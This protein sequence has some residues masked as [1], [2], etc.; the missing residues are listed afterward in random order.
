MKQTTTTEQTF[1]MINLGFDKPKHFIDGPTLLDSRF[2]YTIGELIEML[3]TKLNNPYKPPLAID[4]NNGM[5]RVYYVIP[6][7]YSW[8]WSI[9]Y[10]E[11]KNELIDALF[12]MLVKL[13]E[14]GLI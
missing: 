4:F 10:K 7:D 9:W 8:V 12:D 1:T 5:W 3:P 6:D 11:E 14:E 13:K 2:A